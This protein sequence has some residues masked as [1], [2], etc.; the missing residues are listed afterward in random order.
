MSET[1]TDTYNVTAVETINTR[2]L[3]CTLSDSVTSIVIDIIREV[4]PV[5]LGDNISIAKTSSHYQVNYTTIS[6]TNAKLVASAGGLL[7]ECKPS[8]T[9][10]NAFTLGL[11]K[12][13]TQS[14]KKTKLV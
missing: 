4:F 2:I 9:M 6:N 10:D 5:A 8:I 13:T 3:R 11:T 1:M 14:S 7:I 12:V